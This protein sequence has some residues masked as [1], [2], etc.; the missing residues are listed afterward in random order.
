ME[1]ILVSIVTPMYNGEKYIARTIESVLQQTYSNWEMIIVD[2]GSKD[3]GAGIVADYV[4]KDSRIQLIRKNNGGSASARNAGL[5]ATKGRYICFLDSDDLWLPEMLERQ[6]K[7]LR[8]KPVGLVYAS[9]RKIDQYGKEIY[10]PVIVPDRV[11]Y[12]DLLKTN[13][14]SCLTAMFDRTIVGVPLFD[15][16]LKSM[17][18]DLAYWLKILEKEKYAYG[19]PN[20]LGEYRVYSTS[21]TGNKKKLIKPT[22]LFYYK[23]LDLGIIR[24]SYYTLMWGIN[25]LK[26]YR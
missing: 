16:S 20:I 1:E 22:F 9:Y 2:D 3:T 12:T 8:D 19:N 23:Y 11:C 4:K 24:S 10:R 7:L 6:A 25:G 17:R 18:D 26:K 13:S 5:K 21:T 15:E 14:I